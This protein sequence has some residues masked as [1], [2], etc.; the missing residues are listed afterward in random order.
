MEQGDST[1]SG[2]GRTSEEPAGGSRVD[3]GGAPEEGPRDPVADWAAVTTLTG[4]LTT[5]TARCI[6]AALT[7]ARDPRVRMLGRTAEA[8]R[9]ALPS[10]EPSVSRSVWRLSPRPTQPGNLVAEL[11]RQSLARGLDLRSVI[12]RNAVSRPIAAA[13]ASVRDRVRV[14]PVQLQLLLLDEERFVVD[15][16]VLLP[17]EGPSG[18]LIS[19]TD[20]VAAAGALWHGT[21]ARSEPLPGTAFL[22]TERQRAVA[23]GLLRGETDAAIARTLRVSV[24]TV[25]TEVRTLMNAVGATSRYQAAEMFHRR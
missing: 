19:D 18:W 1:T 11:N 7:G 14:A 2:G 21:W 13:D 24:R 4:A 9:A 22:M 25:A 17:G 6:G 16:P 12:N 20:A 8:V 10:L 23:V 15:G 3:H 5:H